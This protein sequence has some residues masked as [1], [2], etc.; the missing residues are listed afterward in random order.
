MRA[1]S[2]KSISNYI[3][4]VRLVKDEGFNFEFKGI[5]SIDQLGRFYSLTMDSKITRLY[6]TVNFLADKSKE[7]FRKISLPSN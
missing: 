1:V 7:L 5:T 6:T 3:Y 2:T 4:E